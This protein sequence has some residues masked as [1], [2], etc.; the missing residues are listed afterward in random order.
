MQEYAPPATVD[1]AAARRRR[2]EA[3]AVLPEVTGVPLADIRLRTRRKQKEGGQY[4]KRGGS[5]QFHIVEEAGLKL[6]VNLD[7]YLDTGL[8]LDHRLTRMRIGRESARQALPQPV[9]LHRRGHRCMPRRVAPRDSP[10]HRH[11]AHL[12]GLGRRRT[13]NSMAWPVPQHRLLQADAIRWLA[14]QPTAPSFDL[15]FLD[16]PTFSNSARMQG[17]LDIQRDHATLIEHCMRILAPDWRAAV[18]HEFTLFPDRY[19]AGAISR[20]GCLRNDFAFRFPGQP[21]HPS[22][23][24]IARALNRHY[25]PA[26][27]GG[28]WWGYN[29]INEIGRATAMAKVTLNVNGT[30]HTVDVPA[31]Q[32]LLWVLRDE[33]KLVGTKF[34][35]GMAQ[36]GACT[37]HVNGQPMRSCRS[38]L[39]RRWP[40]RRS[41][42]SKASRKGGAL[43]AVQ[44]AWIDHDVPQCGYCQAGQIMAATAL[45]RD[46]KNPTDADIDSFMQGNLCRCG[47]YVRIRAAIKSA[48]KALN[49]SA[50]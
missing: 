24:R 19:S 22:L 33:L 23:L 10:Q 25:Q 9:L 3:L 15:I 50:S 46:K 14:D 34:G 5:E 6:R 35:C 32:P 49:G 43:T 12:S 21:A 38:R 18:L 48:A 45:L 42:P 7:D 11:V 40:D 39:L 4:A 13:W 2:E 37:V 44:K 47:T 30:D 29:Q 1:P 28:A 8:F 17:V 26:M 31:D 16:P 41:P 36:C 20:I 27:L